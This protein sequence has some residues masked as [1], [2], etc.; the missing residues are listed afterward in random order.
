MEAASFR[1]C[2]RA[3]SAPGGLF[4][5]YGVLVGGESIVLYILV[6]TFFAECHG[7]EDDVEVGFLVGN[8]HFGRF[9]WAGA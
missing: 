3:C 5:E 4:C 2:V 6:H 7:A 8:R 9:F 1:E